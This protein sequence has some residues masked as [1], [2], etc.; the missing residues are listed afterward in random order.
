V[1]R[2]N[3]IESILIEMSSQ[4]GVNLVRE[5]SPVKIPAYPYMTYNILSDN[6]VRLHQRFSSTASGVSGV[7]V[8]HIEPTRTVLSLTFHDQNA[9]SVISDICGKSQQWFGTASG[10]SYCKYQGYVV[11]YNGQVQDRSVFIENLY[12]ENKYGYDLNFDTANTSVESLSSIN[13]ITITPFSE[14]EQ[15][16]DITVNTGE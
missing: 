9:I 15:L 10:I 12:W 8:S 16:P 4:V 13:Q 1:I 6:P 5:H 2:F 11:N 14:S 7:D 3:E